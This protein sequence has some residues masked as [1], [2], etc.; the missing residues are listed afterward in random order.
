[1]NLYEARIYDMSPN[2]IHKTSTYFHCY[3]L[4]TFKTCKKII[5]EQIVEWMHQSDKKIKDLHHKKQL[6]KGRC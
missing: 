2:Q 6:I 5:D 4:Y 3:F 1:M